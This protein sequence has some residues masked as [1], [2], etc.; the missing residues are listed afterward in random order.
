MYP[1]H[2]DHE[3]R[4]IVDEALTAFIDEY[5]PEALSGIAHRVVLV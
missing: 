2:D 3:W 1:P 5:L 4:E